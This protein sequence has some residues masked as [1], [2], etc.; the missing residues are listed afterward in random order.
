MPTYAESM[1]KCVVQDISTV[2]VPPQQRSWSV[3]QTLTCNADEAKKMPEMLSRLVWDGEEGPFP[4]AFDPGRGEVRS[5]LWGSMSEYM[6]QTDW[7]WRCNARGG[8]LMT[9]REAE[10]YRKKM[11]A[12]NDDF[13]RKI[14]ERRLQNPYGLTRSW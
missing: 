9:A 4:S 7:D 8:D 2:N 6:Y 1:L 11:D 5:E 13:Q 12:D 3:E 10:E 14:E